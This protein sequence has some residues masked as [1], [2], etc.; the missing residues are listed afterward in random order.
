MPL[1]NDL[2]S[3]SSK[4]SCIKQDHHCPWVNNC[5]GANNQKYFLQFL[6][7]VAASSIYAIALVVYYWASGCPKPCILSTDEQQSRMLHFIIVVLISAL[8][9]L[10]SGTMMSDQISSIMHVSIE[11][12]HLEFTY[13]TVIW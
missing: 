5:V 3:V 13:N 4:K 12:F 11:Y 7:W 2:A 9:G 10:F 8:F 6:F 1:L